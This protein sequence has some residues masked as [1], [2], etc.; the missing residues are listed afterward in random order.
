MHANAPELWRA[1]LETE[2]AADPK[3][4]AGVAARLGFGRSYVSRALATGRS[5]AGFTGGVP[6][7]FIDRVIERLHVIECPANYQKQPRGACRKANEAAPTHNPLAM[8]IWRACQSCANKPVKE[9][10]NHA[11]P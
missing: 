9:E 5:R 4:K 6:Q 11:T 7:A 10:P 8:R 1:L 2:V 3:G